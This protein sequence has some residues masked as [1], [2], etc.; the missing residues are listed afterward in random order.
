MARLPKD[1]DGLRLLILNQGEL[2][3]RVGSLLRTEAD[4]AAACAK[5]Q[6]QGAQELIVTRG[7]AGVIFTR[8]GGIGALAALQ[9]PTPIVDVTGAGD[10]FAAAVCWSLFHGS[11]DLELACLRGLKLSAMTLECEETVCPS[12]SADTLDDIHNDIKDRDTHRGLPQLRPQPFNTL[13][14]E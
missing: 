9:S 14:Q 13:Y 7:D 12:L 2:E 8:P 10:A 3:T 6:A 1:L 5:V 4:F 11:D